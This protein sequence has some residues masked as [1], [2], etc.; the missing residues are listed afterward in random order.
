M[1]SQH[2]NR[3]RQARS[4]YINITRV[5]LTAGIRQSP[6]SESPLHHRRSRERPSLFICNDTRQ[7]ISRPCQRNFLSLQLPCIDFHVPLIKRRRSITEFNDFNLT[8]SLGNT[9]SSQSVRVRVQRLFKHGAA[10]GSF[11][12][13]YIDSRIFNRSLV[14]RIIHEHF[15]SNSLFPGNFDA[16]Q[17]LSWLDRYGQT[18]EPFF[19]GF[20]SQQVFAARQR[21]Y[22]E[23]T[24]RIAL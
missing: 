16:A 2:S 4:E 23:S 3:R 13:P 17:R 7:N 12:L 15:E 21:G 20:E 14:V 8:L 1:S 11:F 19:I 9:Q 18:A 22:F 24:F 5:E 6:W 10:G